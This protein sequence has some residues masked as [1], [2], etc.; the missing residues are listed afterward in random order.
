MASLPISDSL[1]S[2]VLLQYPLSNA[3]VLDVHEASKR[4]DN[5]VIEDVSGSRYLLRRYRRNNQETRV[6][7]QLRFQQHLED[8]GF[9]TSKIMRT[10]SNDVLV[11]EE[12]SPWALF[13][14]VE[15]S[16]YDY[17]RVKQ[18]VEAARRLAQ[19]HTIAESFQHQEVVTDISQMPDWWTD[20]GR[21][22]HALEEFFAGTGLDNEITCVREYAAQLVH[23][24]PLERNADLRL[25]WVH[26]DYHG[27]NMVFVGDEM[28][29]LF[30]FDVVY[31]GFRIVDVYK[32]IFMFGRQYR[33]S[34]I[35]RPDVAQAFLEEYARN[36][37]LQQEE[38]QVLPVYAVLD[39]IP[40][41]SYFAMLR[42]DGEDPVP[43]LR[44]FVETMRTMRSE[45]KRIEPIFRGR[46]V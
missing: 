46:S 4:N 19:F 15:G 20:A 43:Y 7:F 24:W 22:I 30:D 31:R 1:L 32:A 25:A 38:L 39:S 40:F 33:G 18:V 14:F 37:E 6:R 36:T 21:E 26:G 23:E 28:R 17:S 12:G 27:R 8:S 35:I 11:V 44:R 3:R 41:V 29:G 13:T 10:I 34:S 2:S 16:E 9:P 5:F 45:M 42:R